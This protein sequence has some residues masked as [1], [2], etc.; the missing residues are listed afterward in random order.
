[1]PNFEEVL[2]DLDGAPIPDPFAMQGSRVDL[3]LGRACRHALCWN[4]QDEQNLSGEEKFRRG[5]LALEISE[6]TATIKAEEVVLLKKCI[7]KLFSP[8]V[9]LRAF[10]LLD[11]EK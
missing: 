8:L 7:A 9:V 3:T 11:P 4:F 2:N 10:N 5:K 6:G 1:M